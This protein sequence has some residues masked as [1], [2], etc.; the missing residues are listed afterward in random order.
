MVW[1]MRVIREEKGEFNF[2]NAVI[3]I[4]RFCRSIVARPALTAKE[5]HDRGLFG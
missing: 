1:F 3:L 4:I 2:F 5:Q